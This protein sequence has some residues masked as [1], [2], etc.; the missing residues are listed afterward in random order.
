MKVRTQ[1]ITGGVPLDPLAHRVIIVT[2][3]FLLLYFMG[4]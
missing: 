2:D 3:L 1:V 4:R